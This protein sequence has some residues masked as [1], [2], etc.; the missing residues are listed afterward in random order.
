[1]TVGQPVLVANDAL[2]RNSL[3]YDLCVEWAHSLQEDWRVLYAVSETARLA[4][5]H[6]PGRFADGALET[7]VNEI[8]RRLPA[9]S[10]ESTVPSWRDKRPS[11][12]LHIATAVFPTGGHSRVLAKWVQRDTSANHLVVLTAQTAAMPDF[13]E[14]A[15]ADAGAQL[16]GMDAGESYV[17]RAA[18]LRAMASACDRVILHTHPSDVVPVLAFSVPGGPPVAMF[19]HAHFS[20][21]L[22][23]SVSDVVVNTFEYFRRVS[24]RLRFARHTSRMLLVSGNAPPSHAPIDKREAKAIV[25]LDP[26]T[27]VVLTVATENYFRPA[28]GYDF[29]RAAERILNEVPQAHLFVVGVDERSELVAPAMRSHP[30]CH[31]CGLVPDP[32]PLYRAADVFLESFPMPSLGAVVEAVAQGEAFPVPVYGAED[33]ILRISQDP[34]LDFAYRPVSEDDYVNYVTGLLRDRAHMQEAARREKARLLAV[35]AEWSNDLA[36]LNVEIDSFR[37]DVVELPVTKMQVSL[38]SNVLA[39][40]APVDF[41]WALRETLPL[42][43]AVRGHWRAV[44]AGVRTPVEAIR[45]TAGVAVRG[46]RRLVTRLAR[47]A[48][49]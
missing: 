24:E 19:N 33:S 40:F 13:F 6:H 11:V 23:T 9:K 17:A 28:G 42:K 46:A 45:A 34:I 39:A 31:L 12:T 35:D 20:F 8:G 38:D 36:S 30:R 47:R 43:L 15:L 29:F 21:G 22:G 26:L 37:H 3:V 1:M 7:L 41:D 4:W 49:K 44:K 18:T 32:S 25:G 10:V 14:S 27:P 48:A 2:R 16:V 5:H